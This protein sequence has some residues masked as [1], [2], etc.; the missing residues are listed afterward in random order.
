MTSESVNVM[1]E[2]ES[3]QENLRLLRSISLSLKII[4][5]CAVV[6]ASALVLFILLILPSEINGPIFIILGL[7]ILVVAFGVPIWFIL[8]YARKQADR[9]SQST[10][11]TAPALPLVD[12]QGRPLP[13]Q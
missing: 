11:N 4:A 2:P 8:R 9:Y 1:N 10:E 5:V 13:Q 3:N 6:V 7:A 12:E